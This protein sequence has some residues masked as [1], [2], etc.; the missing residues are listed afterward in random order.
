MWKIL[1]SGISEITNVVSYETDTWGQLISTKLPMKVPVIHVNMIIQF[2]SEGMLEEKL[3]LNR[4]MVSEAS[5]QFTIISKPLMYGDKPLAVTK[6]TI[7][8]TSSQDDIYRW[9]SWSTMRQSERV[10]QFG[11]P[12]ISSH[13][14]C[15]MK[16]N[17]LNLSKHQGFSP[18]CLPLKVFQ[19]GQLGRKTEEEWNS[20]EQE[21]L[22]ISQQDLEEKHLAYTLNPNHNMQLQANK[23]EAQ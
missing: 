9:G 5:Q 10:H 16:R 21:C 3:S 18:C 8:Q 19:E 15:I 11:K 12:Q 7:S 23:Q 17:Q 6:R 4:L 20:V 22:G 14:S 13:C 2:Y 1:E